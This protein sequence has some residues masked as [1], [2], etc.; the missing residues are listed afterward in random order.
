[1]PQPSQLAAFEGDGAAA[2]LQAPSW[3]SE[4]LTLS[5]WLSPATEE[6]HFSHLHPQSHSF[7]HYFYTGEL[8]RYL[9]MLCYK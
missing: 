8:R 4:I 5:L 1:M 7:C 3:M 6:T 9:P 2:Q